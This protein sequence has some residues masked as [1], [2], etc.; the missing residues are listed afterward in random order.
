M[1]GSW[2]E[3]SALLA[4]VGNLNRL[5]PDTSASNR[6]V[7]HPMQRYI[8]SPNCYFVAPSRGLTL[9]R[10]KLITNLDLQSIL[11]LALVAAFFTAALAAQITA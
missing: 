8:H 7:T 5:H 1:H 2:H 4:L 3:H 10:M 9:A 6:S 11:S